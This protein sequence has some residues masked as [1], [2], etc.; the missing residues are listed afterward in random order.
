[1]IALPRDLFP[2]RGAQAGV[3]HW[4]QEPGLES[5]QKNQTSIVVVRN[6]DDLRE[7]IPAWRELAAARDVRFRMLQVP[8][9]LRQSRNFFERSSIHT[10]SRAKTSQRSIRLTEC[11]LF[12]GLP[13]I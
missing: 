1:M 7:F 12:L 8:E 13:Y 10:E 5:F 2:T 11:A 4:Q 3:L 9:S 6:P